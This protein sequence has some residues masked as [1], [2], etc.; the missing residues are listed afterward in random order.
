MDC[1]LFKYFAGTGCGPAWVL[2]MAVLLMAGC[3]PQ[4]PPCYPIKGNVVWRG[5]KNFTAGSITFQSKTDQEIVAI[6]TI[7]KDGSFTVSTKM[8]GESKDG[9]PEGE[10]TVMVEDPSKNV[11]PDGQMQIK[12]MV[13]TTSSFKVEPKEMNEFKVEVVQ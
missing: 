9:A 11:A 12:P 5:G 2:P 6:G 1:R 10:Y 3:G 13:V 4:I 8:F 7:E